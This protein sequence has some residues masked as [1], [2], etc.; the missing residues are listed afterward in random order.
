MNAQQIIS[1]VQERASEYLE[2]S[3]DP[4]MFVAGIL[5]NRIIEL[6]NH[7]EYLERRVSYAERT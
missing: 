7:I 4:A 2:M 1:E 6:N 5:A 3:Q